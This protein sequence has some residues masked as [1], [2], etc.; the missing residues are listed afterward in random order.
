VLRDP[1]FTEDGQGLPSVPSLWNRLKARIAAAR[2]AV[3]GAVKKVKN[4][5]VARVKA[6]RDAVV[7]RPK[8][9]RDAVAGIGNAT[10]EML[11]AKRIVLIS[12]CAGLVVGVVCLV[13]P[14]TVAASVSAVSVTGTSVLVQ[15]GHWL[16]RAALRFG[17]LS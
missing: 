4:T 6:V 7:G 2:Q 5:V 13:T 16:K 15:I 1:E 11:P 14:Q 12:L 3:S 9:V 17:L 10:G 8:A